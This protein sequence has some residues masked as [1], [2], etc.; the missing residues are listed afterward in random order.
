MV[1]FYLNIKKVMVIQQS[2][3]YEQ[4]ATAT[5]HSLVLGY[6]HR[7]IWGRNRQDFSNRIVLSEKYRLVSLTKL[8][9]LFLS[10][11]YDLTGFDN[12]FR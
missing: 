5:S 11:V 9:F 8:I 10:A 7:A 12:C 4:L 1:T 3:V 6:I 2:L